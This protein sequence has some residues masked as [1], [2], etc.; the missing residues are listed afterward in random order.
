M[1]AAAAA[2]ASS[3]PQAFAAD[4]DTKKVGANERLQVATIGVNGQGGS[5]VSELLKNKDVELVAICDVD[6]AAYGKQKKKFDEKKQRI[7]DYVQDIRKLLARKDIDAVT[8]AT[9]NHWHAL[10]A[11]WAMQAGKDVYVEKPVSHN[12]T[13]GRRMVEVARKLGRICQTGTQSRSMSGMRQALDYIHS[14]KI[15]TVTLAKGFCYKRRDSI[16]KADKPCP[17]PAG[18]DLD[19]WIG[20]APKT[21]IMRKKFHYDWHWQWAYGN[22]D[23]GNQGIH[24]MDKARWGLGKSELPNKVFSLGGRF[25]YEDDGET[26]NT[27]LCF[28]DWDDA[29]LIFEVRGLKSEQFYKTKLPAAD[30]RTM[31]LVGNIWYGAKGY[32]VSISYNSGT[33]FDLEG[34]QLAHFSGG[35]YED[36]FANF[37]KAVRSRNYHDLNA[38]IEQ[39]HLSSA[40]CH[41]GNVSYRMGTMQSFGDKPSHLALTKEAREVYTGFEDHLKANGVSLSGTQLRVGCEIALDPKTETA[42]EPDCH[43]LF[44]RDYRKGFEVPAKA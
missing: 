23:L 35:K 17:A 7:P 41:L 30:R 12:V 3:I 13:E 11:I 15:G 39:G 42:R 1:F 28:Y 29:R 25:G 36:H 19:L 34:K 20:P 24:E 27:Q 8:I 2:A 32:V 4:K 5:H 18:L 37:V 9:P 21:P 14:G 26:A 38:D 31:A 40:L 10:A 44:T 43:N 16:G 22:G 6:P 33:A